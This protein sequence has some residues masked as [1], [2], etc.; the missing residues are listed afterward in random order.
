MLKWLPSTMVLRVQKEEIQS[1]IHVKLCYKICDPSCYDLE[2]YKPNICLMA[3][4]S[5]RDEQYTYS[6]LV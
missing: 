2:R 1:V 6:L 5:M 3:Q 4:K